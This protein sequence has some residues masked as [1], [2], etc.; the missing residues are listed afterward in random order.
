MVE[1][2]SLHILADGR[3]QVAA[4]YATAAEAI[5]GTFAL[6][7]AATDGG[8]YRAVSTEQYG[9]FTSLTSETLYA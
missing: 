9:Y 7:A 2:A 6:N 4:W 5:K 1:Y 3:S 8:F